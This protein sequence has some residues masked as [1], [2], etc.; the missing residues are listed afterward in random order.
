M[1]LMLGTTP[2]PSPPLIWT[3]AYPVCLERFLDANLEP[4]RM[5]QPHR[6][7][8]FTAVTP[9]SFAS[10]WHVLKELT[11]IW[12]LGRT[13]YRIQQRAVLKFMIENTNLDPWNGGTH[14]A[15]SERVLDI[16]LP[17]PSSGESGCDF[18]PAHWCVHQP[19]I[20]MK[21]WHPRFLLGFHYISMIDWLFSHVIVISPAPLPCLD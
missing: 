16:R 3:H 4:S 19:W 21:L 11:Q 17:G 12:L 7:S 13:V 6:A 9:P 14:R 1:V 18:F 2:S 5:V 10:F 20:S 15:K 8:H